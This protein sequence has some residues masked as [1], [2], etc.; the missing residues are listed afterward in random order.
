MPKDIQGLRRALIRKA[1]KQVQLK[2]SEKDVHI[3]RAVSL[4][5]D[6]DNAFNLLAENCIEWYS[7]NFPEMYSVV[8]DNEVYLKIVKEI[9]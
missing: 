4:L 1:K 8:R 6:L 2:Y 5:S 7:S 9:G 3:I